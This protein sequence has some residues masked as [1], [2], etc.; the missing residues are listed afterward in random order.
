MRNAINFDI[1]VVQCLWID[2][3]Q[4]D[5]NNNSPP[6]KL[7]LVVNFLHFFERFFFVNNAMLITL[8][9]YLVNR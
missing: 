7:Q 8:L 6:E 2:I 1:I 4:M 9:V 5:E 3:M